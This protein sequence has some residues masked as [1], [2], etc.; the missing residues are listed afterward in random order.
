VIRHFF[1]AVA[2]LGLGVGATANAEVV[3]SA[4]DGFQLRLER[5]SSASADETYAR[6]LDIASWWQGS[7]TY[8]GDAANLSLEGDE[9]GSVWLEEWDNGNVEHGHV[10]AALQQN[11]NYLI[12]FEAALGPLQ[13][14]G[15]NAVLTIMVEGNG[16]P[17]ESR[18]VFEYFVTGASFQ[19][20]SDIAPVVDAVL[21][22]QIDR[23][24]SAS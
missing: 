2:F 19:S 9:V 20:L 16:T 13:N 18:L 1:L 11:G 23:L 4:D 14:I 24:A 6:L 12:R 8:S 3:R 21:T 17:G 7:H 15:V 22:T 10:I 5:T